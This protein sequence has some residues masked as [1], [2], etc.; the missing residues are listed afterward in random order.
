MDVFK[1]KS[2]I[3]F[4]V[5]P[6]HVYALMLFLLSDMYVI[7]NI[8]VKAHI[9]VLVFVCRSNA[10]K[11]ILFFYVFPTFYHFCIFLN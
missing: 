5:I 7:K 4:Y 8:E 1:A 11:L 2:L 10:K 9:T 3:F 6:S